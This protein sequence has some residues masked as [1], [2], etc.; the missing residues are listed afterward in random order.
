MLIIPKVSQHQSINIHVYL[1][2]EKIVVVMVVAVDAVDN[3]LQ[4]AELVLTEHCGKNWVK[5]SF[6]PHSF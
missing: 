1:I 4:Q 5:Y 6:L 3:I 2:I